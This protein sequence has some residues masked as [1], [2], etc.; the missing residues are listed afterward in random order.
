MKSRI[1]GASLAV[2]FVLGGLATAHEGHEHKVMGKVASVTE[3]KIEVETP[4]GKKVEA[5]LLAT[6]KYLR[7]KA[8]VA[9]TDIKVGERVVIVTVEEKGQ[10]NVKQVLLGAAAAEPAKHDDKK[11]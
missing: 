1:L 7:D 4:D 8:T 9:R 11:H 3:G 2:A 10:K 6:T 5:V